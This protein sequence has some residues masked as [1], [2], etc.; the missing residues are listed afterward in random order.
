M[1][2]PQLTPLLGRQCLPR[3]RH[4]IQGESKEQLAEAGIWNGKKKCSHPT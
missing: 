2:W 4:E 1:A 3:K